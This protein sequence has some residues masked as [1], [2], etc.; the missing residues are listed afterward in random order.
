LAA[1][2]EAVV[3]VRRVYTLPADRR[4]ALEPKSGPL[5]DELGGLDVIIVGRSMYRSKILKKE[6]RALNEREHEQE[7]GAHIHKTSM[8]NISVI[9]RVIF[10]NIC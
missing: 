5:S 9:C 8:I 6:V 3:A 7:C 4:E 2:D 10:V 1:D